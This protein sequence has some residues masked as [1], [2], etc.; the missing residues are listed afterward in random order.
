MSSPTTANIVF[1]PIGYVRTPFSAAAGMPIQS[2]RSNDADGTVELFPEFADGLRDLEGFDRV[3]LIYFFHRAAA[4]KMMVRPFLDTTERGVF[5]TRAPVRPNAI[6]VSVVRLLG[7]VGAC[8][9]I[10]EVDMIDGTPLLDIKPYVPEFDSFSPERIG[11][12]RTALASNA[13]ADDRFMTEKP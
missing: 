10:A 5:A 2:V 8:L 11:W 12:Y 9:Q 3:W 7:I 4:P 6:G 1:R 13:I